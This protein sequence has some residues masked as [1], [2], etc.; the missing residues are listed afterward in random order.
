MSIQH[1][2]DESYDPNPRFGIASLGSGISAILVVVI[3]YEV[4]LYGWSGHESSLVGIAFL[5]LPPVAVALAIAGISFGKKGLKEEGI[6]RILGGI[7]IAVS[8][9]PF[10]LC[11]LLFAFFCVASGGLMGL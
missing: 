9:L 3:E 1:T 7:G 6:H 4:L 2:K 5:L 11:C 10:F 8:S